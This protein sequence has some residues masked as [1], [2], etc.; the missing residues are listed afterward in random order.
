MTEY[1]IHRSA[2]RKRSV[3]INVEADGSIHVLAPMRTSQKW[4]E[5]FVA[6]RTKWISIRRAEIKLQH[7][8]TDT[9]LTDGSM[10]SFLGQQ[11]R[12]YLNQEI[13]N[14]QTIPLTVHT[15]LDSPDHNHEVEL[16]LRLWYK[17]QA[18]TYF[19][20]RAEIWSQKMDLQ[21]TRITVTSP[22]RQWG[23]C[24]H[25]NIIRL[26]WRL[27][28]MPPKVIDYVIIHE[29]AHIKHK[30]HGKWFWGLVAKH[31]P[32]HKQLRATLRQWEKRHPSSF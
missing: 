8:A 30:N 23:S 10:V 4:I 14:D 25:D 9:A 32:D 21:P 22:N 26:N 20:E 16:A 27:I 28:V 13:K 7:D 11:H 3:A 19:P 5:S 1:T 6:E 29:I 18:R 12:L 31:E 15:P 2:R 17:K 24:S